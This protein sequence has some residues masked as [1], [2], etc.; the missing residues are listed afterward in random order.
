MKATHI[1][2]LVAA[3]LLAV[4]GAAHADTYGNT[5]PF[6]TQSS[7]SPNFVLG[8][9]VNIPVNGFTVTSFGMMYGHENFTPNT[10]NAIFGLYTSDGNGLPQT[11]VAVTNPINLNAQQTYDNIAFTS[12]PTINSG[13]YWM[14]ALYESLASPRM[15]LQDPNS[16]VAYWSNPYA[17]GMPATAPAITTY[18]GQNFNYWINGSVVPAPGALAAFGVMG[19]LG[20]R[21]RRSN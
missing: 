4:T 3:G 21:R 8:V 5:N 18:T 14:M 19:L 15:G 12:T 9:R 20:V 6:E 7:H 13:T 2:S 11:L 10:S 1:A 17:N 16:L